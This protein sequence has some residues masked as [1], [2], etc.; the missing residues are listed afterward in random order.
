MYIYEKI[1]LQSVRLWYDNCFRR[2]HR[3]S[4]YFC[5][6]KK[7]HKETGCDLQCKFI[8]IDKKIYRHT[9][10]KR[11]RLPF[12]VVSSTCVCVCMQARQ[13]VFFSPPISFCFHNSL[14]LY[15]YDR[16]S[17]PCAMWMYAR[18]WMLACSVTRA[19]EIDTE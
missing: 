17:W 5:S 16:C 13:L 19:S 12:Y 2:L 18:V 7:Q 3:S 6:M 14:L 10:R 11:K 1:L 4:F 8:G 9:K 15:V